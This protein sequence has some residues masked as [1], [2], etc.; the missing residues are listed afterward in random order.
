MKYFFNREQMILQLNNQFS[1]EL[2][3]F[4]AFLREALIS[5]LAFSIIAVNKNINE[6]DSFKEAILHITKQKGLMSYSILTDQQKLCVDIFA[7]QTISRQEHIVFHKKN[8]M[9]KLRINDAYVCSLETSTRKENRNKTNGFTT[10]FNSFLD[11][12]TSKVLQA[13]TLKA[14]GN[15]EN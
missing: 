12:A 5:L 15:N 8:L 2:E 3:Q 7:Q 9:D 11:H 14:G 13:F 1:T 10:G 4:P 6:L